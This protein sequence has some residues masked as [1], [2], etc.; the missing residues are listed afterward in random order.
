VPILVGETTAE[1]LCERFALIEI[2]DVAV[3]GKQVPSR[4]FALLGDVMVQAT[5]GFVAAEAAASGIR[6]AACN[7]KAVPPALVAEHMAALEPFGLV[8]WAQMRLPG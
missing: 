8:R 5:P 6:D 4:I 3:K 1:A 2:D 7:G